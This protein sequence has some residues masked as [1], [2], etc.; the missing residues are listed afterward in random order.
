MHFG[1]HLS[2]QAQNIIAP[3][4]P[5]TQS[6]K[7]KTHRPLLPKYGVQL[8]LKSTGILHQNLTD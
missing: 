5:N 4:G 3:C 1:L 2:P 6:N 8:P 7:L